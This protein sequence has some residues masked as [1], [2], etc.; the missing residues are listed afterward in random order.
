MAAKIVEQAREHV[1]GK[2]IQGTETS[3]HPER[4]VCPFRERQGGAEYYPLT[5]VG[6]T[7]G[8]CTTRSRLWNGHSRPSDG[9]GTM[10]PSCTGAYQYRYS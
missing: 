6:N 5:F 9:G 10:L 1:I 2:M 7:H 8:L 3:G 4:H